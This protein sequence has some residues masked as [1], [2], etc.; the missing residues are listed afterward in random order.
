MNDYAESIRNA[1]AMETVATYYGFEAN[2]A[3]FM[4]CPFHG[5]DK[6][7][8]L[9]IYGGRRGWHCYGCGHGG[10]II[11][12]VKALYRID[13]ISACRKLDTDFGL[14]II[15]QSMDYRARKAAAQRAREL[16]DKQAAEYAEYTKIH[17]NYSKALFRYRQ[18][19]RL[20]ENNPP[21]TA[22][23]Q[24]GIGDLDYSEY[25]LILSEGRLNDWKDRNHNRSDDSVMDGGRVPIYDEAI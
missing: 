22:L 19:K 23:W 24:K 20:I 15:P 8:S 4:H 18:N 14:N 5:G 2:R 17:L 16:A 10:D 1:L 12:F 3:G 13:F 7:P 21:G 11:D 9:K 6:T 25:A